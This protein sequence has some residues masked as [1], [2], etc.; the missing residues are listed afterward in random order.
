MWWIAAAALV[1][2]ALTPTVAGA[3]VAPQSPL[4]PG[5]CSVQSCGP[6]GHAPQQVL[7]LPPASAAIH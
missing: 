4:P 6:L 3:A 1:S 5:A 7:P 2:V